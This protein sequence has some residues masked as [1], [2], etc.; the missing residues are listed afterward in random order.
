LRTGTTPPRAQR[1]RVEG[2]TPAI[3]AAS[4]KEITASATA[5]S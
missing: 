5:R 1:L 4:F 2:A 3:R